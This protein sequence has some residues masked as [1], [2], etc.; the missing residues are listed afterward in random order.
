MPNCTGISIRR[1]A[2]SI[3]LSEEQ[4]DAQQLIDQIVSAHDPD[5]LSI[6]Q[7]VAVDAVD[8]GN[9]IRTAIISTVN[10]YR[11]ALDQWEML[12]QGQKDELLKKTVQVQLNLLRFMRNTF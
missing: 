12:D 6:N 10:L 8:A 1:G 11:G 3:H 9:E 7:Q 5:E 4:W 2:L